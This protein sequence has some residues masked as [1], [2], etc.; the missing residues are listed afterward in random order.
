MAVRTVMG[1]LR[2]SA[3]RRHWNLPARRAHQRRA[4][5]ACPVPEDPGWVTGKEPAP[6][7]RLPSG[8]H[9]NVSRLST[10]QSNRERGRVPLPVLGE[11]DHAWLSSVCKEA[12]A[13]MTRGP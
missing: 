4:G 10:L 13:R 11:R 6:G 9:E 1:I 5:S 8:P 12:I 7:R 2:E 3:I